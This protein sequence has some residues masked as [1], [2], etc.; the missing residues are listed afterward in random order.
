MR[1]PESSSHESGHRGGGGLF[2]SPHLAVKAKEVPVAT[3]AVQQS[4]GPAK[5]P[6]HHNH[7]HATQQHSSMLTVGGG[8][9]GRRMV[10]ESTASGTDKKEYSK[11]CAGFS[12]PRGV[13]APT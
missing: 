5:P 10:E 12:L 3:S 13:L 2:N 7:S 6:P 4:V 1:S 9:G 8:G 11:V